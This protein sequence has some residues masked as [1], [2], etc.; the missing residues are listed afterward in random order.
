MGLG[1]RLVLDRA[2]TALAWAEHPPK[3]HMGTHYTNLSS[4]P[5]WFKKTLFPILKT[6]RTTRFTVFFFL[7][8]SAVAASIWGGSYAPLLLLS[9]IFL[10][11]SIAELLS[12][13]FTDLYGKPCDASHKGKPWVIEEGTSEQV[14]IVHHQ[15]LASPVS[16]GLPKTHQSP[17]EA[18][19]KVPEHDGGDGRLGPHYMD[20]GS[21]P[22]WFKKTLFPILEPP[23][24]I[25]FAVFTFFSAVLLHAA[26]ILL[27]FFI[28]GIMLL[29]SMVY[30]KPC[31]VSHKGKPWVIEYYKGGGLGGG[32]WCC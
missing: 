3:H 21:A 13:V 7:L 31:D 12:V 30:G 15:A 20:F 16:T 32:G 6:S 8:V 28:A 26:A 18:Y 22:R 27:F 19:S 23:G 14:E 11:I 29:V 1:R 17:K 2:R 25:M 9:I 10:G 4:A 5:R 24:A